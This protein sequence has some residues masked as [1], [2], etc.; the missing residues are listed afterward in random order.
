MFYIVV[1]SPQL[2]GIFLMLH[3]ELMES[4][5]PHC[6]TMK[7]NAEE[8]LEEHLDATERHEGV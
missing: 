6:T 4:D 1:E 7:K 2:C 8:V 5:I 3:S